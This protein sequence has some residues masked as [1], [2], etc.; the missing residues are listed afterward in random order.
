MHRAMTA[1]H[2]ETETRG[3]NVGRRT[4]FVRIHEDWTQLEEAWRLLE[5][6]GRCTVFQTYDWVAAWYRNA[7]AFKFA[8]PLI[9]TLED[10]E[11]I[12]WILPLCRHRRKGLSFISFADLAVS[13]YAGPVMARDD[14]IAPEELQ[15]VLSD[16][17]KALPR[18]NL[19]NFQKLPL[20]IEGRPNP[21]LQIGQTLAMRESCYGIEVRRPWAELSKEIM[22]SRLR[23][24]IRQQKKK[25]AV[26]GTLSL[27]RTSDP[28]AITKALDDLMEMRDGR[29]ARIGREKM[30][31]KWRDFYYGVSQDPKRSLDVSITTLRVGSTPIAACFGLMRRNAYHVVMPTFAAEEWEAYRPGMLMFDAML[32]EFGP[33]TRFD[34]FFDFT[35]GDEQYKARFGGKPSPLLECMLPQDLLGALAWVY[36]RTKASRRFRTASQNSVSEQGGPSAG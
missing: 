21:V 33:Q 16:I 5:E 22:Q 28:V 34:G 27:E 1:P 25:I 7:V 17:R 30:S 6:T 8:E 4:R 19:I 3:G 15:Q 13:D 32:E 31:P 23:S 36:W 2:G 18:C 24:T 11:G 9:A 12:V 14:R 10:E 29:F 35:I 20:Q 26:H